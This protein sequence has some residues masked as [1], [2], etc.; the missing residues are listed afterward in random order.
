MKPKDAED[1]QDSAHVAADGRRPEPDAA[2]AMNAM[3]F[4]VRALR[5]N[6][7]AIE[8]HTGISFAQL[9]VLQQLASRPVESLGELAQRTATHVSSVSV[10]VHRLV[11]R[12]LVHRSE[13]SDDHRRLRLGLTD[14]GRRMLASAPL[15]LQ[16]RLV[17]GLAAM[18]DADREMLAELMELWLRNARV[19]S[20][21]PPMFSEEEPGGDDAG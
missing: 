13:S 10:V 2:R 3:L 4:I 18:T 17:A 5:V 1:R 16:A 19:E 9:F 14:D 8:A 12:G 6:S 15:T 20:T 21:T 7:R 11:D